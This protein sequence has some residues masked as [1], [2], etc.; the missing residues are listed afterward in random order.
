MP[1]TD[2]FEVRRHP[3]HVKTLRRFCA[4][5]VLASIFGFVIVPLI[6]GHDIEGIGIY[7]FVLVAL[8]VIV[9]SIVT[10]KCRCPQCNS[11]IKRDKAFGPSGYFRYT[12]PSCRIVWQSQLRAGADVD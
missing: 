3:I 1:T 2:E 10:S 4:V 5:G 6:L 9:S 7:F 11:V 8:T 12:C